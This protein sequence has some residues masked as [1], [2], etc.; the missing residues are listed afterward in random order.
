MA[1]A[2]PGRHYR[3]GITLPEL[4]ALFPTEDA[5]RVWFEAQRWPQGRYCPRCVSLDTTATPTNTLPYWCPSCRRRFS[6]TSGTALE[7]TRMPLQKWAI[8][9]YLYVTSLKGV[10]S[11]KLHRDWASRRNPLG[12]SSTASAWRSMMSAPSYCPA[13]WKWTR[14]S[15][16][17]SAGTC[18]LP[19]AA[20]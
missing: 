3:T 13:P 16:A 20:N 1:F 12:L 14:P 6:V 15:W 5:A 2:A 7:R 4:F 17:A 8:A 19:S 11:M 9:I 10:S 18:R